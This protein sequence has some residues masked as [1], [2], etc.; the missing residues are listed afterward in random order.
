MTAKKGP[1]GTACPQTIFLPNSPSGLEL[2][3]P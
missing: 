2:C 1:R 3:Y